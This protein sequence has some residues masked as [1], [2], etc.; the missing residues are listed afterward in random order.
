MFIWEDRLKFI[1]R[2]A[3]SAAKKRSGI[4]TTV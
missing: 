1:T 3:D 4:T 2:L